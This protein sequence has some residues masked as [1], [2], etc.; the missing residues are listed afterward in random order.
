MAGEQ[1]AEDKEQVLRGTF[2]ALITSKARLAS[3]AHGRKTEDQ[4]LVNLGHHPAEA[5]MYVQRLRGASCTGREC[6][7]FY[8]FW[9]CHSS[10][11]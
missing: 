6:N 9:Q 11:I 10:G 2:G 4:Q 8:L 5:D 3:A 7:I 1:S